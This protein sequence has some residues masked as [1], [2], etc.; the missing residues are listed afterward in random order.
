MT[1]IGWLQ[2]ALVL[3]AVLVCAWPLC[4]YLARVFQ[5]EKTI[6]SPF[7][8]P[9]EH[10]FYGASGIKFETEQSWRDY[11]LEMLAFNAIG[12]VVL[13]AL[14]R[15]QAALPFNPQALRK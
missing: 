6:L 10:V 2:I 14:M 9:V 8:V 5:G 7:M 13:Y 15:M 12:F 3:S 4:L 11:A 1:F